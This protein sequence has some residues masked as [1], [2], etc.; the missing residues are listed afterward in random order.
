MDTIETLGGQHE[1]LSMRRV[2]GRTRFNPQTTAQW[3]HD[4]EVK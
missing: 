4:S 3:L 2:T 1:L